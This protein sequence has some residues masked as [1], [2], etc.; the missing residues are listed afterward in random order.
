MKVYLPRSSQIPQARSATERPTTAEQPKLPPIA[1]LVVEDNNEVR[2]FTVDALKEIGCKVLEASNAVQARNL[3]ATEARIDV[4]F[5]DI[6]MPEENG[7]ELADA[8]V[9]IRPGLKLLFTT[10][11]SR[12][13]VIHNGIVDPGVQLIAKPFTIAELTRRLSALCGSS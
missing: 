13:A 6:V 10:G 4:L 1:V 8:A 9:R 7:R 12:N 5:T 2:Q 3:L 11:Y